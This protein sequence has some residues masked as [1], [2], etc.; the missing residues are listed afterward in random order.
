MI[1]IKLPGGDIVK[2]G[3]NIRPHAV[4]CLTQLAKHFELIIFT[5]S[6]KFYAEKVVELLDPEKRLFAH[7]LFRENCIQTDNGLYIKDLRVLNRD[8]RSTVIA[9]NNVLSFAFQL[10]NGIPVIPFYDEKEDCIMLK[11]TDYLMSLKDADDVRTVNR[12][13]FSLQRMCTLDVLSFLKYYDEDEANENDVS[14]D[15]FDSSFDSKSSCNESVSSTTAEGGDPATLTIQR[16]GPGR[17][18]PCAPCPCVVP[19]RIRR[20]TKVLVE[21]E[22]GK[23]KES[24]PIYLAS[25]KGDSAPLEVHELPK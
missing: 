10:D 14:G 11:I 22:L 25:Q 8:L 16:T 19:G 18:Q 24:F 2:A 17:K 12:A 9:D 4:E 13:T 1:Q 5:A 7:T 6:H 21:S 3:V 23:F 15:S 20:R